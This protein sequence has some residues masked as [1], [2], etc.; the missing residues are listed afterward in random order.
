MCVA[1]AVE[2]L[3]AGHSLDTDVENLEITP[4]IA[5]LSLLVIVTNR[6]EWD[7]LL[8]GLEELLDVSLEPRHDH[9]P[10]L[11]PRHR[12]GAAA[13]EPEVEKEK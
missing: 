2:V 6:G 7:G 12:G 3:Q 13:V 8:A 4:L 10:Q 1:A 9:E 11:H 5:S